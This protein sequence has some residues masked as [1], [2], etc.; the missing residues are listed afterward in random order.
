MAAASILLAQEIVDNSS[1][2][3][4]DQ[5][6]SDIWDDKIEEISGLN[7]ERDIS[8]ILTKL[9]AKVKLNQ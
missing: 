9:T 2:Q 8:E 7:F 6:F 1:D 5:K 4:R 3:K